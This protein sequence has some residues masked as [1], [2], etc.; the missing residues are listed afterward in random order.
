MSGIRTVVLLL[1]VVLSLVGCHEATTTSTAVATTSDVTPTSAPPGE[2]VR[3]LSGDVAFPEGFAVPVGETWAFDPNTDTTVT[4]SGNVIVEGTLEMKPASGDVEHLLRFEDVDESAFVGGGRDPVESDVGL[5]VTGDGRLLLEGE[6][7]TA[8]A[9]EY[10]PAWE[11][12]EVVAAPNRPG[13]YEE[14]QPVTSTP[15]ANPLGYQ[16]ELLDLTRNVRIEGTPEGYTH[17]FIRSTQPQTIRYAALRWVAPE[18]GETDATGR[19]G[20]HFHMTGDGSRG[21]LVEGV[22]IRDT[23]N[24]AFVAHASHGVTFRNT[25]AYHVANEA[26]WWDE[27]PDSEGEDYNPVNDTNDL[28][29]DHA[30][31]AGVRLGEGGNKFRLAAFFLGNGE[32]VSVTDSVAVGVQGEA[33]I[34]H[35]GFIWPEAAGAVW[36]FRDNTAHNN[37]ADGIFTWQNN[38]LRHDVDDFTAYYNAGAGVDHGAYENSYQYTRLTLLENGI[39]V[40]SHALG[41]ASEGADT[42]VWTDIRTDGGTLLIT[43]HA[44]PTETPVRFVGCDFGTVIVADDEGDEPSDYDFIECG[45][46][47]DD[48]D[49]SQASEDSLF[50]VQRD[51]GSAFE[52]RGDGTVTEIDPFYSS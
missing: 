16:T 42:Q 48:F 52:L 46:E 23:G 9:Y 10:D 32:N 34:E 25:I 44:T 21:S 51:D 31:A 35:S 24:H 30:V 15:P 50:R 26:Y 3:T 27:P 17:V 11:G 29:W 47:P 39:A 43:E 41:E 36:T 20:I 37:E 49:L 22:V 14:F 40:L 6:E 2:V 38:D 19:Y 45:L 8:W 5:W 12:D 28:I 13:E 4:V 18:L 33:G 7:K 1:A